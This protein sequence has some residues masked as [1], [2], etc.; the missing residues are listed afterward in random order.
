MFGR[1]MLSKGGSRCRKDGN[2]MTIWVSCKRGV[3]RGRDSHQTAQS[4]EVFSFS[5]FHVD[6]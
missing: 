4:A 6:R 3:S 5:D 1:K 2:S